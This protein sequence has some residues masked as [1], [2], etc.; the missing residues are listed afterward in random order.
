MKRDALLQVLREARQLLARPA[1]N[2]DWSAWENADAALR[3]IDAVVQTLDTGGQP[4]SL[5]LRVLFGPT[6]PIQEVSISSG[7]GDTFLT[8]AE[9]FDDAMR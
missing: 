9:R 3:E 4:D 2:F 1:N 5:Q 6:G 8:L 7:W